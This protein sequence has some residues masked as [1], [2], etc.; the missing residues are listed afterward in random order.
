LYIIFRAKFPQMEVG[1]TSTCYICPE[2]E[3]IG[4]NKEQQ[5]F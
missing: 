5:K 4:W 1:M 2:Y 3:L